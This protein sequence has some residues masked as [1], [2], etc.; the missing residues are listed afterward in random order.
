MHKLE[1]LPESWGQV[2]THYFMRDFGDFQT[3]NQGYEDV[4]DY[5]AETLGVENITAIIPKNNYEPTFNANELPDFLHWPEYEHWKGFLKI[6][7]E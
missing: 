4:Q 5:E 7:N 1:S 2:S 6:E 3:Y